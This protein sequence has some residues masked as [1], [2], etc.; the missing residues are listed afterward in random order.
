VEESSAGLGWLPDLSQ[1][2]AA[3]LAERENEENSMRDVL[4]R[5]FDPE[6][7]D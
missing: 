5:L 4:V 6:D 1:S 7:S 2:T 3:M